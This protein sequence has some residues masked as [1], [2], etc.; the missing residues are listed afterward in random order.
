MISG[1]LG[2]WCS[3]RGARGVPH[4]RPVQRNIVALAVLPVDHGS[5]VEAKGW[6]NH[7]RYAD[8]WGLCRYV[9]QRLR[10]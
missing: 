7:V 3:E 8:S 10:R 9:L 5:P 1:S 4:A 6:V 2:F